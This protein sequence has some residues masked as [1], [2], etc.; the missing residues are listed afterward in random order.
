MHTTRRQLG[1]AF[2]GA[3]LGGAT[4]LAAQPADAAT[5]GWAYVDSEQR[6]NAPRHACFAANVSK[7]GQFQVVHS[8]NP[9]VLMPLG[10]SIK[11]YVMLAVVDA[12]RSGRYNWASKFTLAA[13]D[14]S[15]GS[16]IMG[17]MRVGT[18]VTL[19]TA[20][21]YV[22]HL[23][24]NTA[25]S[26]LIRYLGQ[27][28][29][30]HAVVNSGHSRPAALY[31]FLTLHQ[32]MWLNWSP[33]SRAATARARWATATNAQKWQLIAPANWS[34]AR[35]PTLVNATPGWPKGLGYYATAANLAR[36][37][38]LLYKAAHEP[39]LLPLR[40]IMAN[41][42]YLITKPAAWKYMQFK[43]GTVPGAKVGS[44]FAES[45]RGNQVLVMME[46]TTGSVNLPRFNAAATVAAGILSRS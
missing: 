17:G 10:S 27:S 30:W 37:Q 13:V 1:A 15:S 32:D 40:A 45:P 20:A 23:S 35:Q 36:A 12:V 7:T 42:N 18:T 22:L 46:A 34:S 25:A 44:W 2:V 5:T 33:D 43:G 21:T 6:A 14:K 39:R 29:M 8:T 4:L 24:D 28:A 38:M 26:M 3:T 9:D 41:P 31:P 19:Q 16:G 11:L